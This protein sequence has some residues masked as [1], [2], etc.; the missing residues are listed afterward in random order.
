MRSKLTD[1]QEA[2]DGSKSRKSVS[3]ETDA[4]EE[5]R[6]EISGKDLKRLEVKNAISKRR[7]FI[8]QIPA[9]F[10]E[11]LSRYD[12]R[13]KDLGKLRLRVSTAVTQEE[14]K[15]ARIKLW[16]LMQSVLFANEANTR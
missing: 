1:L 10:Q 4:S 8:S 16:I 11:N 13:L 14:L 7:E 5:S 6:K 2:Q 12:Q 9:S 15:V 3:V